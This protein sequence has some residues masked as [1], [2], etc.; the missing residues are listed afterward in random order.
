[1]NRLLIYSSIDLP[2]NPQKASAISSSDSMPRTS[3]I[4]GPLP[5]GQFRILLWTKYFGGNQWTQLKLNEWN[6]SY[7]NCLLTDDRRY[8]DNSDAVL[9]HWRD[10]DTKDIPQRHRSDQKWVLYNWEPPHYTF[11]EVI[12]P[13]IKDIDWWMT[14]RRD[15]D[16]YVPYGSVQKCDRK[17]NNE[18]LFDK[19]TKSVAWIVSNCLTP[20]NREGFVKELA[21]HIDVDIFGYCGQQKCKRDESCFEMIQNTYKFYLSF[22]NSVSFP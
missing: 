15:S 6:C 8:L 5:E 20:G 9:F 7:S 17:W 11:E 10:I 16:I 2:P 22:E 4:D 18:D 13:L 14:Y 1:M 12:K 19:K 21:T 3:T